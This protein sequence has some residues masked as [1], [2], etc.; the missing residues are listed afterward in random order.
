M[1]ETINSQP[2]FKRAEGL[3]VKR[4]SRVI[5]AFSYFM[6]PQLSY[7]R[8]HKTFENLKWVDGMK[9]LTKSHKS[10]GKYR[11]EYVNLLQIEE[12]FYNTS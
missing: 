6:G 3:Q 9:S 10:L 4:A 2:L 8:D 7:C 12:T 5:E 1:G 11:D